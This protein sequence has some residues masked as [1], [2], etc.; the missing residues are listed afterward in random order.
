MGSASRTA[1]HLLRTEEHIGDA[2]YGKPRREIGGSP[3][4]KS[5]SYRLKDYA[6]RNE[7]SCTGAS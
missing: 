6:E 2:C 7:S 5:S 3:M 4:P 1:A